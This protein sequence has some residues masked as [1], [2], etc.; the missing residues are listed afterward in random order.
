MQNNQVERFANEAIFVLQLN[1]REAVRYVQ[2]NAKVERA[3]AEKAI[4]ST[5]VFH[6][7]TAECVAA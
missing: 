1:T 3:M 7:H 6:R 4:K 2:H 5:V